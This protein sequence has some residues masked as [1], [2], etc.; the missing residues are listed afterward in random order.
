M[1]TSHIGFEP[2]R[3]GLPKLVATDLDGTIVR[4]DQTVSPRT[5]AA[6][7][8]VRAL[9]IPVVGVTG[10]GPRLIDLCRRDLPQADYFV[11]GQGARVVDLTGPGRPGGA[12][13]ETSWPGRTSPTVLATIEAAAGPLSVLV[14]P[15]DAVD[16]NLHGD[17]NS[18]W[19]FDDAVV[20]VHASR[21]P[22]RP[23]DQGVRALR[24]VHGRRAA[25]H[26]ARA[27]SARNSSR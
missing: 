19:L 12:V 1:T 20:P 27:W 2:I 10:R 24:G 23:R 13:R 21:S 17:R 15:L 16:T 6:F 11:L 14:E 25:A 4:S 9:G 3:P 22:H 8:R 7:E 18:A 5:Q 26:R